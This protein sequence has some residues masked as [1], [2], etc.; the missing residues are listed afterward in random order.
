MDQAWCTRFTRARPNVSQILYDLKKKIIRGPIFLF[1]HC[2]KQ[3]HSQYAL[4]AHCRQHVWAGMGKG[5]MKHIKYYPDHTFILLGKNPQ[6]SLPHAPG[7]IAQLSHGRS[8][9]TYEPG[10]NRKL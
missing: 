2:T 10:A 1:L 7:S 8:T 5:T 4:A 3:T 6:P 9:K